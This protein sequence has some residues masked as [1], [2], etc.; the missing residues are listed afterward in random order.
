MG[1]LRTKASHWDLPDVVPTQNRQATN[2]ATGI[3]KIR[4]Q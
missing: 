4:Y 1:S 3:P 2:R